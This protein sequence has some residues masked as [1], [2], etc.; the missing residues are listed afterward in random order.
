MAPPVISSINDMVSQ[1]GHVAEDL[2]L[3][4]LKLMSSAQVQGEVRLA[5]IILTQIWQT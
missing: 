4:H 2:F 1:I 5:T 3:I